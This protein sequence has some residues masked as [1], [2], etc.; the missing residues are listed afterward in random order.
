MNAHSSRS[1]SMLSVRLQPPGGGPPSVLHLVDLA[2]AEFQTAGG[3][4]TGSV[5]LLHDMACQS[6]CSRTRP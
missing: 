5:S 4:S 3:V 6:G 1:H 2:G